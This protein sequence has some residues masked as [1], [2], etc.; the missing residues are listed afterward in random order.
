MAAKSKRIA[1]PKIEA[2]PQRLPGR[3]RGV[4]RNQYLVLRRMVKAGETT[5]AELERRGIVLPAGKESDYRK[6]VLEGL[7]KSR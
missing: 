4:T 3:T 1:A 7:K 6:A 2:K 5:W